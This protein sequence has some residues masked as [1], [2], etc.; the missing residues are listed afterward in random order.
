MNKFY[1]I[2]FPDI[3]LPEAVLFGMSDCLWHVFKAVFLMAEKMQY[4][5]LTAIEKL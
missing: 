2:I 3:I 1:G 5:T 4:G